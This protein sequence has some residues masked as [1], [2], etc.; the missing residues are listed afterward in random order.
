MLSAPN[1][2]QKSTPSPNIPDLAALGSELQQLSS[3]LLQHHALLLSQLAAQAPFSQISQDQLAFSAK[4]DDSYSLAIRNFR[5][6][7]SRLSTLFG[8]E[9]GKSSPLDVFAFC[10]AS[11]ADPQNSAFDANDLVACIEKLQN[12]ALQQSQEER[13]FNSHYINWLVG[14]C[15]VKAYGASAQL[16]SIDSFS[17]QQNLNQNQQQNSQS[18]FVSSLLEGCYRK[19]K[20][21][22]EAVFVENIRPI[23]EWLAAKQALNDSQANANAQLPPQNFLSNNDSNHSPMA[24][25]NLTNTTNFSNRN[26][27]ENKKIS[28][29]RT[30]L[31]NEKGSNSK[32][33]AEPQVQP[34]EQAKEIPADR[35]H[36]FDSQQKSAMNDHIRDHFFD[37]MEANAAKLKIPDSEFERCFKMYS[38]CFVRCKKEF[39]RRYGEDKVIDIKTLCA[40]TVNAFLEKCLGMGCARTRL[41]VSKHYSSTFAAKL[42]S[43]TPEAYQ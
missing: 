33:S 36:I 17:A 28:L 18:A 25:P 42:A 5:N 23:N 10:A 7:F 32:M 34:T 2:L 15:A 6:A 27:T 14:L 16:Q 12:L 40:E 39:K 13:E 37:Y 35:V 31:R 19:F 41:I 30:A 9:S 22:A 21:R 43:V 38:V 4:T 8:S 26:Y 11:S 1:F 3:Q 24:L 29:K 20:E